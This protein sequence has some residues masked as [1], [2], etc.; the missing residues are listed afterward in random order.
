[1]ANIR[2]DVDYTIIDGSEIVFRSPVDCSAITGLIVYYIASNGAAVSKVF[3][4]A[5]AHGNNVGDI[6]HLF[7]ED[8]VVKVILD[9]TK[10]MAFVQN[11]DTNAYLENKFAGKAPAGFGYGEVPVSIGNA[12]NEEAFVAALNEQFALTTSKVRKVR[13]TM[14]GGAWTGELWSAGNGYGCLVG[15]SY[16]V[17]DVGWRF[18]RMIRNCQDGVWQPWEYENPPMRSGVEYRTTERYLGKVVYVKLITGKAFGANA[19]VGISTGI[20]KLTKLIDFTITHQGT[21]SSVYKFPSF[22]LYSG[23]PMVTGYFNMD[24]KSFTLQMHGDYS[25]HTANVFVKYTKD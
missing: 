23:D 22:G 18:N 3:A 25:A 13:F 15:H 19:T 7:A 24:N 1:M 14:G 2:V 16:S 6:D 20:D 5:D 17:K 21:S 11:A 8:V 9:V 12:D 10:G 4:F